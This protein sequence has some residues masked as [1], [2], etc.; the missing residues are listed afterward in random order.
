MRKHK[1]IEILSD[2][3]GVQGGKKRTVVDKP[4]IKFWLIGMYIF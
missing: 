3:S 2:R 1:Q 4:I